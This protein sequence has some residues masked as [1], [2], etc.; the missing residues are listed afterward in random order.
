MYRLDTFFYSFENS[1]ITFFIFL[2]THLKLNLCTKPKPST[3]HCMQYV[4]KA[5]SVN[6]ENV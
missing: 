2:V 1:L 5:S 6:V 4:E 3:E